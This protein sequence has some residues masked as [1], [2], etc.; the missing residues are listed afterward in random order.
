MSGLIEYVLIERF[1]LP[2]TAAAETGVEHRWNAGDERRESVLFLPLV[3]NDL[4]RHQYGQLE[5]IYGDA[6]GGFLL[7]DALKVSLLEGPPIFGLFFIDELHDQPAVRR[8]HE[9]DPEICFFMDS[10]NVWFYGVKGDELFSYD[11]E[12]DELNALGS[13]RS[14]FSDLILQCEQ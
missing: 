7:G 5:S 8:A 9:L 11:A 14:A 6:M 1:G 10:A 12:I 13:V 3:W 2:V 4:R